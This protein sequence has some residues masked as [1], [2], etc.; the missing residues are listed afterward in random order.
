MCSV[1]F[2]SQASA[3]CLLSK[4]PHSL[5][6]EMTQEL[7]PVIL[8]S[9]KKG[10]QDDDVRA[11]AAATLV[12]VSQQLITMMPN[13]APIIV[14]ILWDILLDLDDL[15]SSTKSVMALLSSLVSKQSAELKCGMQAEDLSELVPRLWPFLRH[16]ISAVRVSALETLETLLNQT[17][18]ANP[19]AKVDC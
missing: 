10:L 2:I 12:P 9:I 13:E 3:R 6:Q 16:T 14:N 8:P 19:E 7:L 4:K 1:D 5:F 17:A 15:D 11:V 18:M